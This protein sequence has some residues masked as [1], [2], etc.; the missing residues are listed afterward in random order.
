[1]NSTNCNDDRIR[2]SMMSSSS[3][4]PETSGLAS[5]SHCRSSAVLLS[6]ISLSSSCGGTTDGRH[7]PARDIGEQGQFSRCELVLAAAQPAHG[8]AARA[9]TGVVECELT[10]QDSRVTDLGCRVRSLERPRVRIR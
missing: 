5:R 6:L 4:I 3:A 2:E 8:E 9:D 10:E 7:E 1:M